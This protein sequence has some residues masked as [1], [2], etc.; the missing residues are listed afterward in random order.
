MNSI[1]FRNEKHK[2]QY[3]ALLVRMK[4]DDS[5]HKSAAYLMALADLRSDAVFDFTEDGIKREGLD[6]GWQTSSS[7][8]ATRLMFN[9]WNGCAEE[10]TDDGKWET[11]RSYAVDN[12]FD[13]WEYA[14]YF[15][16]AIRIRFGWV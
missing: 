16:E 10:Q 7:R 1:K 13:N 12:I 5:Y 11:S 2:K 3:Q 9:L 8:K 14:P 6:E 15:Y 4:W